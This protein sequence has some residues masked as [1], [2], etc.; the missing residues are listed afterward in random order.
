MLIIAL[1]HFAN[2]ASAGYAH[3]HSE[4]HTVL[5]QATGAASTLSAHAGEVVAVVPHSR[6]SWLSVTLPPGSQGPRL[7]G[8]LRGLLEDRLL[9][10]PEQLHLVLEPEAQNVAAIG[11]HARLLHVKSRF[12]RRHAPFY[13]RPVQGCQE[14][15]SKIVG[16]ELFQ[17]GS[18]ARDRL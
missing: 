11:G 17:T 10:E 9:E 1:P 8:V 2:A 7:Q 13:A 14:K 4:G 18:P 6:L 15:P 16:L 5:R 3:V 12:A